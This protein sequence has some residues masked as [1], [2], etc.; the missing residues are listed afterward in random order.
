MFKKKKNYT[1]QFPT[2]VN[3]KLYQIQLSWWF[4]QVDFDNTSLKIDNDLND[5]HLVVLSY[6]YIIFN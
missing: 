2:I 6:Y 3:M 5:R 1:T 4:C